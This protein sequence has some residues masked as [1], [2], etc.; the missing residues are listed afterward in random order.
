MFIIVL[1]VCNYLKVHARNAIPWDPCIISEKLL[2]N[3]EVGGA[4]ADAIQPQ[5]FDLN[6]NM[7]GKSAIRKLLRS[8]TNSFFLMQDVSIYFLIVNH[9]KYLLA[10]SLLCYNYLGQVSNPH[11]TEIPVP[12]GSQEVIDHAPTLSNLPLSVGQSSVKN[13]IT[14][15]DPNRCRG[16]VRWHIQ[17]CDGY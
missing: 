14:A 1:L 2:M 9:V 8:T 11:L 4:M 7:T 12:V 17:H 3:I 16:V 5:T 6:K 10:D 13:Y 15:L